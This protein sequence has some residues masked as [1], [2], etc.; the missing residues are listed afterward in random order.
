MFKKHT[1][2]EIFTGTKH[3]FCLK[4]SQSIVLIINGSLCLII[5]LN[6]T[7]VDAKNVE[8]PSKTKLMTN[9]TQLLVFL[10]SGVHFLS[11]IM[12]DLKTGNSVVLSL[13]R[14]YLQLSQC[15]LRLDA[16]T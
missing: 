4:T 13:S 12:H 3:C 14:V 1:K 7:S 5:D 16:A 6:L 8:F 9:L 11:V 10:H 2:A 15:M